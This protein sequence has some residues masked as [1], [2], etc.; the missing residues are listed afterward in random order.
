MMFF[1]RRGNNNEDNKDEAK[2]YSNNKNGYTNDESEGRRNNEEKEVHLKKSEKNEKYSYNNDRSCSKNSNAYNSGQNNLLEKDEK[3]KN[4]NSP[5]RYGRKYRSTSGT[6]NESSLTQNKFKNRDKSNGSSVNSYKNRRRRNSSYS[7]EENYNNSKIRTN[8]YEYKYIK[9]NEMYKRRG[10]DKFKNKDNDM[11]N[12]RNLSNDNPDNRFSHGPKNKYPQKNYYNYNRQFFE[13][14]EYDYHHQY[15]NKTYKNNYYQRDR[16]DSKYFYDYKKNNNNSY[17]YNT[18]RARERHFSRSLSNRETYKD[19]DKFYNTYKND[20]YY[21]SKPQYK[22]DSKKRRRDKSE[23]ENENRKTYRKNERSNSY[24]SNQ[25]D[26]ESYKGNNHYIRDREGDKFSDRGSVYEKKE[27]Y[28]AANIERDDQLNRDKQEER[29]DSTHNDKNKKNS[30]KFNESGREE[31]NHSSYNQDHSKKDNN[32]IDKEH[33]DERNSIHKESSICDEEKDFENYKKYNNHASDKGS[34]KGSN[35]SYGEHDRDEHEYYS[36]GS[37]Y[38]HENKKNIEYVYIKSE[39]KINLDDDADL[40]NWV[41][42]DESDKNNESDCI[43]IKFRDFSL[44]SYVNSYKIFHRDE[45]EGNKYISD[46]DIN[47]ENK[48]G[49]NKKY[50]DTHIPYDS[51]RSIDENNNDDEH[52]NLGIR[53]MENKKRKIEESYR[54]ENIP[55]HMQHNYRKDSYYTENGMQYEKK[56]K[57]YEYEDRTRYKWDNK[58]EYENGRKNYDDNEKGNRRGSSNEGSRYSSTNRY[59]NKRDYSKYYNNNRYPNDNNHMRRDNSINFEPNTKIKKYSSINNDESHYTYYNK[60]DGYDKNNKYYSRKYER[61]HEYRYSQDRYKHSQND[62]NEIEEWR[63]RNYNAKKNDLPTEQSD[64]GDYFDLKNGTKHYGSNHSDIINEEKY[65]HSDLES[66]PDKIINIIN[67]MNNSYEIKGS[68]DLLNLNGI[69]S[70]QMPKDFNPINEINSTHKF[71]E[72]LRKKQQA[73]KKWKT[74]AKNIVQEEFQIIFNSI[75]YEVNE[76]KI[77]HLSSSLATI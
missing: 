16:N 24:N 69:K 59:E 27:K 30:D 45:Y 43:H 46:K 73:K 1:K 64:E 23:I 2:K 14:K 37:D 12:I 35:E 38:T 9:D 74:I 33:N 65:E 62:N 76:A 32:Y 40:T 36:D 52:T 7:N 10:E 41:D 28:E 66:I 34:I 3:D 47:D 11:T 22:F 72:F 4:R 56:K 75:N 53:G 63:G 68:V 13:K 25:N 31:S 21:E 39:V 57:I 20:R 29:D 67:D 19:D 70:F 15:P 8:H 60:H 77:K 49:Y 17:Y 5:D 51:K 50:S 18:E 58:Y 6:D 71:L 48:N 26:N 44:R 54:G 42:F 55:N 61:N